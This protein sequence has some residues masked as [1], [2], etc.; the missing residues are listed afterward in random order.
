[1]SAYLVFI[2]KQQNDFLSNNKEYL[3]PITFFRK[4]MN[5]IFIITASSL[6]FDTYKKTLSAIFISFFL[7]LKDFFYADELR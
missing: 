5:F 1:L 6:F 4:K 3:K 2:K 7:V